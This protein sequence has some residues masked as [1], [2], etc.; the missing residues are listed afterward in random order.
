MLH[1]IISTSYVLE[2]NSE[3]YNIALLLVLISEDLLKNAAYTYF[4]FISQ[5]FYSSD[6]IFFLHLI[7]SGTA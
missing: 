5:F 2:I 4:D 1:F 3:E 7:L 6:R